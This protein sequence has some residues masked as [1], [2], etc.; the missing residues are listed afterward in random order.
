MSAIEGELIHNHYLSPSTESYN[1][2]K[3][4][5]DFI[6]FTFGGKHSTELGINRVSNGSRY[7]ETLLPEFSNKTVNVPG[8]N[9]V[10]YLGMEFTQ[11]S[12]PLDIAFDSVTEGQLREM[13]RL[14]STD[15]PL[16]L[17]FDESPYKTYYAK[18]GG[19]PSFTYICFDEDGK[20]IYRG[21]GKIDLVS[22]YPYGFCDKDFKVEEHDNHPEW[23]VASGLDLFKYEEK[24]DITNDAKIFTYT[25]YNPGDYDS[26]FMIGINDNQVGGKLELKEDDEVINELHWEANSEDKIQNETIS[27]LNKMVSGEIINI[28]DISPI[29]HEMGIKVS[30]VDDLTSVRVIKFGKNLCDNV[31][32]EG[33]IDSTTGKEISQGTIRSK[34]YYPIKP[35]TTYTIKSV[36]NIPNIHFRFYDKNKKYIGSIFNAVSGKKAFT[37]TTKGICYFLRFEIAGVGWNTDV[38][39]QL[40]LGTS[41]TEYE[42]YIKPIGY[43]PD[44]DG[45]VSGVTSLYPSTTLMTYTDDVIIEAS[46]SDDFLWMNINE[47]NQLIEF[48]RG[49]LSEVAIQGLKKISKNDKIGNYRITSGNWFTIPKNKEIELVLTLYNT[50]S[51]IKPILDYKILY[52]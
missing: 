37:F 20:R 44:V 52:I 22:F 48:G 32:E 6:G 31:F 23:L 16:P 8:A 1:G 43:I 19:N 3:K 29:E 11:K 2:I 10:D 28:S 38:K 17:V 36:D 39:L 7:T 12:F 25:I 34:N 47:N 40:E 24:T 14:F 49:K 50:N 41:A 33:G 15:K 18:A 30:G 42:P 5:T 51:G 27:E 45:V 35:N 46:Y 9:R 21:E 26:P 13:K 4:S